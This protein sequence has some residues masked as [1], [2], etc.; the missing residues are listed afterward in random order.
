MRFLPKKIGKSKNDPSKILFFEIF[1]P[2]VSKNILKNL[3]ILRSNNL[4]L[5]PVSAKIKKPEKSLKVK[6]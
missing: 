4:Y 2:N 1:A 5:K 3:N 6:P